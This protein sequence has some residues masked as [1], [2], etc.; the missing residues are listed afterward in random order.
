MATFESSLWTKVREEIA[1]G[2]LKLIDLRSP[3]EHDLGRIPHA[4][5]IPLLNNEERHQ[6]GLTYKTIGQLQ[7]TQMGIELFAGKADSFL[8][9]IESVLGDDKR[10]A[11]HCWRGGM[12]SRMV[13][14]WLSVMGYKVVLL[15]GGYKKFRNEVLKILD[16]VCEKRF[17]VLNGRTGSG[18]T[19]VVQHLVEKGLSVIDLE[20]LAHHRGSVFGGFAQEEKSPTQQTFDNNLVDKILSF[21]NPSTI[22]FEIEN[23]IGPITVPK[24]IRDKIYSSEMV[25]ISRDFDDRVKKLQD[26]YVQ[27]WDQFVDKIFIERM[28]KLRKFLSGEEF[29]TIINSVQKREFGQ[30]IETLLLKRYDIVYNKGLKKHEHLVIAQYNITHEWDDAIKFLEKELLN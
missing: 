24:G 12:R 20:G 18:K 17:L 4:Y 22:L 5:N 2:D 9:E 23:F 11:V 3:K 1:S 25:F 30:A 21:D 28:E 6:V 29:D 26:E 27:N 14:T 19:D 10:V 7:A 8:R 16:D 15:E 13:A